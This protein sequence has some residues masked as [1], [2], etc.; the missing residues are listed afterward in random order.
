FMLVEDEGG[1]INLIVPPD[2]YERHRLIARTE[3]LIVAEGRLER[4]PAGG[5]Q[6]N[7]L[8]RRL[9]ALEASERPLAT[10]KDLSPLD[11]RELE[12]R[13]DTAEEAVA[14]AAGGG[15]FRAVAPPVMNFAQG[16]RR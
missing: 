1:T 14:A 9:W 15:D 16:R 6:I 10:V 5:G 4:H 7:V 3:P 2:I 13:Q 12:R 8:V 11:L